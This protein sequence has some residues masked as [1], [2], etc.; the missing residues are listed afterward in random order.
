MANKKQVGSVVVVLVASAAIIGGVAWF[1]QW[2]ARN[3]RR[4]QIAGTMYAGL[5]SMVNPYTGQ[6]MS[7][8][9]V[10]TMEWL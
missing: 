10:T 5:P 4:Q 9:Q 7:A 6:N 1:A 8:Q 2:S 3:Q